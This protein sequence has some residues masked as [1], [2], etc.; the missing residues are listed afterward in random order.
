MFGKQGQP[1]I[2][3]TATKQKLALGAA[4]ARLNEQDAE[5]NCLNAIVEGLTPRTDEELEAEMDAAEAVPLSEEMIRG[6]S[7][8]ATD[9]D[10]RAVAL[11][12]FDLRR[13]INRLRTEVEA[14][15]P[16]AEEMVH[17]LHGEDDDDED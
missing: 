4:C 5:I 14:L 3:D 15:R 2:L 6:M 17:R 1:L 10:Y 9:D 13:E 8:F 12:N 11:Q 7:K 16:L